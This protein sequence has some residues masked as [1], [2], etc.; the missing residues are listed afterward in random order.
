MPKDI[1]L[2]VHGYPVTGP[3]QAVYDLMAFEYRE[4]LVIFEQAKARG[5]AQFEKN[6]RNYTLTFDRKTY[7]Y[8]VAKRGGGS[9]W[10]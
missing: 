8:S 2:N 6:A 4:A 7:Q 1:S 5:S 9:G 10:F 3:E